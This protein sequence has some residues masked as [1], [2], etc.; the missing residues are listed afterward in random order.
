MVICIGYNRPISYQIV[1]WTW[2]DKYVSKDAK[3]TLSTPP[4]RSNSDVNFICYPQ[5]RHQTLVAFSLIVKSFVRR[6]DEDFKSHNRWVLT[7]YAMDKG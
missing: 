3:K 5:R 7:N 1:P 6:T 4:G 2:D